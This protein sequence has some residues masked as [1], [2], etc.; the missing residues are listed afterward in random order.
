[1]T[2]AAPLLLALALVLTLG[3]GAG[4]SH[5]ATKR[6]RWVDTH[7]I[8]VAVPASWPDNR[9]ACGTPQANTVLWNE[10]GTT[11]CLTP[12]PPG[13]S[14]AEFGGILVRPRGWYPRH[15]TA[16]RIDGVRARRW[17]AGT[18]RGSHEVQLDF[19]DRGIAVTVLS[20]HRSLL[21]RILA[22]V[23]LVRVDEA[24]CPTRPT[25]DYRLG[26]RPSPARPLVPRKAIRVIACS[27][28]EQW[29]DRS[30][31][32][33]SRAARHLAEALDEAPFGFSRPRSGA[34]LPSICAPTWHGSLIGARF[35][36][37]DR[38]PASVTAH[39]A[40][41]S[42]LGASNGRWAVRM[43]PRWVAELVAAS[44]YGDAFPDPRTVGP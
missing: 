11:L 37:G 14:A 29:L 35:E 15:T 22:S 31:R 41:C 33:G 44:R 24:G 6:W 34:Y 40:G 7:G 42:R 20:P 26:E 38:P 18:V 36:Y 2:K 32:L 43:T 4:A 8:E 25:P 30:N 39:L 28:Q 10:D 19:P 5:A 12:Q 13:L 27:Y 21:R 17:N 3:A 16:V 9:G 23:R 1:M